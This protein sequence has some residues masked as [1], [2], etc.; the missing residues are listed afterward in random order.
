MVKILSSRL[1]GSNK[2]QTHTYVGSP[3][4]RRASMPSFLTLALS[5]LVEGGLWLYTL[6]HMGLGRRDGSFQHSCPETSLCLRKYDTCSD[7]LGRRRGERGKLRGP[8]FA[9]SLCSA[10]DLQL[11]GCSINGGIATVSTRRTSCSLSA[12]DMSCSSRRSGC[13]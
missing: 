8:S 3:I 6:S 5:R 11:G 7:E 1:D 9:T 2:T 12:M 13:R 10:S 4:G